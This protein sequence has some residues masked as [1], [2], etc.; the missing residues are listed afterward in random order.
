MSELRQGIQQ[1]LRLERMH[2]VDAI[3]I[4]QLANVHT[5]PGLDVAVGIA[6]GPSEPSGQAVAHLALAGAHQAHD[7]DVAGRPRL[8]SHTRQPTGPSRR[9][10]FANE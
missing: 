5:G 2:G 3:A 8:V 7:H 9:L 1:V 6:P 10:H 4:A